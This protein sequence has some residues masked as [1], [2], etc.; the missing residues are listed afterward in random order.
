MGHSILTHAMAYSSERIGYEFHFN[1][2]HFA[3]SDTSFQLPYFQV[4]LL[5]SGDLRI[6]MSFQHP[7]SLSIVG[8]NYLLMQ[9]KELVEYA[10]GSCALSSKPRHCLALLAPGEGKSEVYIIPISLL[11]SWPTETKT[12]LHVSP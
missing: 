6:A 12:I 4:S 11:E 3:I 1:A 8:H 7:N 9:Q 10:Y 5:S 2:Y